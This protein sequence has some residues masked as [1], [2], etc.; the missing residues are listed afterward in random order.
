MGFLWMI[1]FSALFIHSDF[2][3]WKKNVLKIKRF[4][5]I[6]YNYK[7]IKKQLSVS[8]ML[9]FACSGNWQYQDSRALQVTAVPPVYL[10]IA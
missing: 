8:C 6:E 10:L 9:W 7:Q 1:T 2:G 5:H 4:C 3:N